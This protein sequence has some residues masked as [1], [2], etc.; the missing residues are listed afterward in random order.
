MRGEPSLRMVPRTATL[1]RSNCSPAN[2][3]ISGAAASNSSHRIQIS[4]LLG[5][6][7]VARTP[8][9]PQGISPSRASLSAE[10]SSLV[11]LSG[12]RPARLDVY[13]PSTG[14]LAVERST[15]IHD[16]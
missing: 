3:A 16:V 5:S 8:A 1:L 4:S 13:A 10:T 9:I 6:Y 11:L 14:Y 12:H 15:V 7:L 2:A